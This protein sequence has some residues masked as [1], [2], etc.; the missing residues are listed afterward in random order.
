MLVIT[1]ISILTSHLLRLYLSQILSIFFV[2]YAFFILCLGLPAVWRIGRLLEFDRLV[3][4]RH[5]QLYLDSYDD[6][7]IIMMAQKWTFSPRY[8]KCA[9]VEM[10][11]AFTSEVAFVGKTSLNIKYE[12]K[13]LD[14]GKLP[15]VNA[16]KHAVW[17]DNTTHLPKT[18]PSE[19]LEVVKKSGLTMSPNRLIKY[20]PPQ[21][22]EKTFQYP[23]T[24]VPSDMDMVFH[25]NQATYVRYAL[26]CATVAALAGFYQKYDRDICFYKVKNV[27]VLYRGESFTG[28]KLMV[29]TWQDSHDLDCIHFQI[30]KESIPIFF[31]LYNLLP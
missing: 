19:F 24:V 1:I 25:T 10:P 4:I 30:F 2:Y 6:G 15:L 17:A 14:E 18:L 20:Q 27:S 21:M 28:D 8:Y 5:P 3:G 11:M 23:I 16:L 31:Q 7:V 9:S 12:I 26:D 29:S 22:P 13:S